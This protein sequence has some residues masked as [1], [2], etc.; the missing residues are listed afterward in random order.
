MGRFRLSGMI[1]RRSFF[2]SQAASRQEGLHRGFPEAPS[3]L[4]RPFLVVALDPGIEVALKFG[5]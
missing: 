3:S 1:R 2:A 5:D 4:V